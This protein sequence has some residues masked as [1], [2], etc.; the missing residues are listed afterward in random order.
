MVLKGVLVKDNEKYVLTASGEKNIPYFH[1]HNKLAPLPVLLVK[2]VDE[3]GRV[4]LLKREKRPYQGKW[5]M[6]GGR[7]LLGET[8]SEGAARI[9]K[10]KTFLD[11]EV[12]ASSV[13]V[14]NERVVKDDIVQHGFVLLCITAKPI[15][16][17]KEKDDVKW[18]APADIIEHE[19][20]DSDYYYATTAEPESGKE[21]VLMD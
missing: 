13:T 20:I 5:S 19:T 10:R 17:I 12:D 2:V 21:F 6:P 3:T 16:E 4:L 7:L 14:A 18:F 15:S 11:V 8:L 9:V 1:E